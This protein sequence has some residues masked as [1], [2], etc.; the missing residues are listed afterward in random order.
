MSSARKSRTKTKAKRKA[1]SK[2]KQ[3]KSAAQEHDAA[4]SLEQI[5]AELAQYVSKVAGQLRVSASQLYDAVVERA[6]GLLGPYHPPY[7]LLSL[8]GELVLRANLP[9]V[10]AEAVEISTTRSEV[11]IS[12]TIPEP[13]EDREAF[14]TQGRP[15]GEFQLRVALPKAV[16]PEKAEAKM[17]KGVLE[18]R[19]PLAAEKRKRARR[20]KISSEQ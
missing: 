17:A 16:V 13:A 3:A 8:E 18:L 12:G 5:Q 4:R 15:T 14:V 6:Q 10:D 2:A 9:G 7:D 11:E 20:V 1:R 19:L